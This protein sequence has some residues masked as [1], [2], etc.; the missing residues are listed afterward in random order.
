MQCAAGWLVVGA[1]AVS[2]SHAWPQ[3]ALELPFEMRG[4]KIVARGTVEG[5]RE[6]RMLIDTGA[7]CT[8][9]DRR[10]ASE[11]KLKKMPTNTPISA[12]RRLARLPSVLVHDIVLGPI[13]TSRTCAAAEIP[14]PG[15]Q[16]TQSGSAP[17][18][19]TR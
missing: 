3:T 4:H 16:R 1:L 19:S 5:G 10:L 8:V 18:S 7:S 17:S 15:I 12:H 9:I 13:R 11:L 6:V 2:G 14:L